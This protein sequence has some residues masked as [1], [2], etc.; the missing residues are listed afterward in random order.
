MNLTKLFN[1]KYFKENVKKSKGIILLM[2]V[3]IPMFTVL[4]LM[5]STSIDVYSFMPLGAI[6]IFLTINPPTL[7]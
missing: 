2:L 3:F 5:N 7:N 4:Q 6:N 1:F